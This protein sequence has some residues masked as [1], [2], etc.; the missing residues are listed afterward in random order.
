MKFRLL[1]VCLLLSKISIAQVTFLVTELP[2]NHDYSKEIYISGDFE[3]WSGGKEA[4]QLT[5]KDSVYSITLPLQGIINYKF[6]QGSWD[7]V[8]YDADGN[9]LE[10][11]IVEIKKEQDTINIKIASWTKNNTQK[12]STASNT[13]SI[14][15][16]AFVIPQ[17]NKT[18]RIW[19]YLPPD[20]NESTQHYP[21]LYM[22]DGQNI[23]D[24]TTSYSG[25]WEVDE[26][27]DKLYKEKHLKL[28]V[29]GID[30]GGQERLNE[31]SPYDHEKYGVGKGKAYVDFIVNTLKPYIDSQYRTL[32]DVKNT[33]IMGS[34]MGGLI[35]HYAA[36]AYPKVFGK[37]GVFSP[38]FWYAPRIFDFTKTS[39]L[40]KKQKWYFL[41]GGK[42]GENTQFEQINQ[43]VSDMNRMVDL[44]KTKRIKNKTIRTKIEP[45]GK[46]N[47]ALWKMNFE[48][49]ILWLFSH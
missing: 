18:R 21:V 5:Q 2:K 3:G 16:E 48:E 10:N 43:T 40:S 11:R 14:L 15:S 38:A 30:N 9:A 4:Y 49:S 27:L 36:V 32:K 39:R 6:T 46:H 34:S 7:T 33:G 1:F 29:V 37:I 41:A 42:E 17:L 25:E 44:L 45:E 47:E 35:S 19:L 31:Y 8:E 26:T 20:Y 28:I 12:V 24:T 23:F 22:H 13:V